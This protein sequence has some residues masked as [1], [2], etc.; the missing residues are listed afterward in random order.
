MALLTGGT[1]GGLF[2]NN[3]T[4]IGTEPLPAAT[5]VTSAVSTPPPTQ[6][7]AQ[8]SN[9]PNYDWQFGA[10]PMTYLPA[11]MSNGNNMQGW[12]QNQG[13]SG[14]FTQENEYYDMARDSQAWNTGVSDQL[15]Q[16]MKDKGYQ[17]GY[18]TQYGGGSG[19]DNI[20]GIFDQNK[21]LLNSSSEG[22]SNSGGWIE[23]VVMA[24]LTSVA[25]GAAG[26][27]LGGAGSTAGSANGSWDVSG[28]DGAMSNGSW[29]VAG[30]VGGGIGQGGGGAE[31]LEGLLT[32]GEAGP[33][34]AGL[35]G[36][37]SFMGPPDTLSPLGSPG[38]NLM[39]PPVELAGAGTPGS[40]LFT[41]PPTLGQAGSAASIAGA[42]G[43]AGAESDPSFMGPPASQAPLG[44][45]GSDLQGPP[46]PTSNMPSWFSQLPQGLQQGL[47]G[48][49]NNL[50]SP[51]GL[52]GLAGVYNA[53]AQNDRLKNRLEEMDR[54]FATDS[55]Y[56]KNMQETLARKDAAAGR[57]S[58]YGPR[59]EKLAADLTTRK[60]D[61]YKDIM[62]LEDRM[63]VNYDSRMK[64]LA[65]IFGS[66]NSGQSVFG[67]LGNVL[68]GLNSGWQ[69]LLDLLG[70]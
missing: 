5:N 12:F 46:A 21:N 30:Q 69:S 14:P 15:S 42:A 58:Q 33:Y 45:P 66:G 34:G 43:N 35:E 41:G 61:M 7:L 55:P 48:L 67:N 27:A 65:G 20:Y 38:S 64:D 29:D 44:S 8:Q 62:A 10:D 59:A 9:Q 3:V 39:G 11:V 28:V 70:D 4:P 54:M 18:S 6:P 52:A 32:G 37:P 31:G 51:Q 23:P 13:Y 49:F 40:S 17:F 24:F 22:F 16:W 19:G 25:G 26:Q 63:S 47:S 60:A 68:G 56:A 50:T 53:N 1:L 57:N 2:K 36:S